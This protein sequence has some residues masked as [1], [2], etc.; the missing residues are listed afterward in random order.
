MGEFNSSLECEGMIVQ[1][2]TRFPGFPVTLDIYRLVKVDATVC[3]M[4]L[5]LEVGVWLPHNKSHNRDIYDS[6]LPGA[7][8]KQG[9]PRIPPEPSEGVPRARG[10]L[11]RSNI[12]NIERCSSRPMRPNRDCSPRQWAKVEYIS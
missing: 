10:G 11:T 7:G 8:P 3:H 12:G 1:R 5:V 6:T 2:H 4:L 9:I